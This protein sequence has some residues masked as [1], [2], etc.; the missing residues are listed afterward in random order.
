MEIIYTVTEEPVT[1]YE[2]TVD[3]YVITNRHTPGLTNIPASK[4]WDDANDQDGLRPD[5]ITVYLLADGMIVETVVITPDESGNWAY[6]FRDLPMY[7]DGG[8]EIDYAVAE[9]PV[10]GYKSEV[11]GFTITNRHVPQTVKIPVVK[12]WADANNKYG[13]RPSS[14]TVHLLADG[15]M[16]QTVQITPDANGD[17]RYTFQAL[18]KYA[19]GKEI[20]YTITEDAVSG[21]TTS[22]DKY[23]VTN[24]YTP[25]TGDTA[26]PVVWLAM[27]VTSLLALA[28]VIYM[29]RRSKSK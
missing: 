4:I 6:T 21:Y 26:Q 9:E 29:R 1:G 16:I 10:A 24:I 2:T 27:M 5:S 11:N 25:P 7:A 22:I 28:V 8:N 18:P 17:W 13:K 14:I 12:T 19:N 3:G 23:H 15:E 20:V